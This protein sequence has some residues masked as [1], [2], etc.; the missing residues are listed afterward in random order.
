MQITC[1]NPIP[2][3]SKN[4][5][6][7]DYDDFLQE[8]AAPTEFP[9]ATPCASGPALPGAGGRMETRVSV[10][11][12]FLFGAA[13]PLAEQKSVLT[14]PARLTPVLP[15]DPSMRPLDKLTFLQQVRTLVLFKKAST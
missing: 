9:P 12:D 11:S 4:A 10:V 3:G 13:V 15:N 7:A 8:S 14:T 2:T 1:S 5:T 6:L